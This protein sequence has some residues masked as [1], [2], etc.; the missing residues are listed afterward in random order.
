MTRRAARVA[1]GWLISGRWAGRNRE[2]GWLVAA[3]ALLA[4]LLAA[5]P[6]ARAEGGPTTHA[7]AEPTLVRIGA[8]VASLADISESDRRFD[9]T[10]WVWLVGPTGAGPED[11]GRT[12]EIINAASFERVHSVTTETP[13]GRYTQ[14]KLRATV[15]NQLDFADFPFDQHTLEIHIED[16]ER[17]VRSLELT[18]D[19]PADGRAAL[20]ISNDLDPQDWRIGELALTT[21]HHREPTNFG[22]PDAGVDSDYARAVLGIHITRRHS[23]RIL[24]TLLLGTFLGVIVAFFAALLP[25]QLAPPRFT[26]LSGA[27][28]VCVAN[29][30]LVDSRLPPGSS[31]GLLDQLQLVALG[32]LIVLTG[33]SLWLTNAAD[34]VFPAERATAISQ[35]GGIAWI[36]LLSVIEAALV[37]ARA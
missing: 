14:V 2:H 3:V 5:Q 10:L 22:E 8:F 12:L 16:A 20:T 21:V 35:R 13:G 9:V 24:L 1:V 27:L 11:P 6:H 7:P 17:D 33:A 36:V 15:R 28:F 29:R 31:L 23:Y 26:L 30:L 4:T 32:G 37:L 19:T 25:I 34:R 18:P